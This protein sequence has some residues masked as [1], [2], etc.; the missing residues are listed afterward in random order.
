MSLFKR[1]REPDP[2]SRTQLPTAKTPATPA[3]TPVS[4]SAPTSTPSTPQVPSPTPTPAPPVPPAVGR[5]V[6]AV[7]DKQSEITGTLHSKGNV[8]IEG[9]FQG[10]IDAKETIL[11]E[12]N[13]RT[14]GKLLA[15]DIII[16]GTSNGEIGCQH[17]L[18]ITATA[19]IT[20]E[21]KTPIL[22]VEDGS[23]VNCCF[24]MTR[25]GR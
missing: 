3:S 6:A 14:E 8:L 17:R 20:G 18:H 10:E 5:D 2:S 22:V 1:E 19:T 4:T 21:V 13:A 24:K 11:V 23:V 25:T 15:N 9:I 7:I 12:K 16:S